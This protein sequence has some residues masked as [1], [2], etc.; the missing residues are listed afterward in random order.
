[1]QREIFG[2]LVVSGSTSKL[3][4]LRKNESEPDPTLFCTSFKRPRFFLF[5]RREPA[6]ATDEGGRDIFNEKPSKEEQA[7]SLSSGGPS[8]LG[9]RALMHT[10]FG[11]IEVQLFGVE[12]PRTVENFSMHS[13]QKYYDGLTF[14]RVIRDFMI[15][16]GCP[17]GDGTGG[18]SI[19]GGTFEDE[20]RS[21]LKHDRAY[22]VSMANC[23]PST[24]GS[25]FFITT[26]ACPHLDRKHTV[27]GRVV[28]GHDIVHQIE[29]VPT[30]NDDKPIQDVTILNIDIT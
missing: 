10:S 14:H 8:V 13:R 21:S 30:S 7:L 15:Q 4:T 2:N 18:E 11:D 6:D 28:K 9:R 23:G 12:C 5:A 22:T 19:W 25:Q 29:R 16:T 17:K 3:L 1:M 27:F 24:N 20:F 26:R